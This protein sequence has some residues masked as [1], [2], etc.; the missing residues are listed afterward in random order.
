MALSPGSHQPK[1][2]NILQPRNGRRS[3]NLKGAEWEK[4]IGDDD[5]WAKVTLELQA[6][7][8]ALSLK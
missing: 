3:K 5:K 6:E 1:D 8:G 7:D 2:N 4:E